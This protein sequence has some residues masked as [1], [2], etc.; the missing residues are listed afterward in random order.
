MTK[1][2]ICGM[3]V[4]ESSAWQA[5]HDGRLFRFCSEHCRDTFL[6]QGEEGDRS[7]LPERPGGGHRR[8][9]LVGAQIGPVPFS[10]AGTY[11]CP[12]CPGVTAE[13]PGACPKCGM[14]LQRNPSTAAE[15]KVVYTCPMHPEIRQDRP[16]ACPKCGMDLVPERGE[17]EPEEDDAELRGMTRR[18]WV[19]VALGLPVL[20]LAMLPMAGVPLDKWFGA[21][22]IAWIEFVLSTPVVLWA[23]WPF[24]QRAWRS[25]VTWNLNMFTLI[26]LGTG[27]A[28]CYSVVVLLFPAIIPEAFR[29]G[30]K[31][32]VY[33]EAAAVI[34]AL[35]LLG[36][37]LESRAH[38]RTGSAAQGTA[39]AGPADRAID[40]RW[41]GT[42]RSS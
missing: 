32:E 38:R 9:A 29:Q 8:E 40:G 6:A 1:D 42:S 14:A 4:D 25:V 21:K 2:P 35:V 5:E 23:G 16:G 26:A 24:F 33:F 10:S 28:Y 3:D 27:A 36:Q 22:T 19:A 34:T 11:F 37:V 30:G 20:L 7:D 39:V 18:F 17:A 41:S 15:A 31:I 12:M 13:K